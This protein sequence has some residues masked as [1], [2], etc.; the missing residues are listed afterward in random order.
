MIFFAV[1]LLLEL[2]GRLP[3]LVFISR[4]NRVSSAPFVAKVALAAVNCVREAASC[5]AVEHRHGATVRVEGVAACAAMP[6][7]V[8]G[9]VGTDEYTIVRDTVRNAECVVRRLGLPELG[10][11]LVAL[12]H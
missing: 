11:L 4:L 5:L 2:R 6:T 9:N 3:G 1:V 7:T 10:A 8:D 12:A